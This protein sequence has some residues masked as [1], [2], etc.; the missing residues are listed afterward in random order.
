MRHSLH[1]MSQIWKK[2][3]KC[4]IKSMSQQHINMFDACMQ[5]NRVGRPKRILRQRANKH[6]HSSNSSRSIRANR[7][8]SRRLLVAS[9]ASKSSPV[10]KVIENKRLKQRIELSIAGSRRRHTLQ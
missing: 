3:G 4:G 8:I 1:V 7:S 6:C 9:K 5:A 10:T 2:C